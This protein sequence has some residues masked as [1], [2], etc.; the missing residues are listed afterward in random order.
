[1]QE[2]FFPGRPRASCAC[3]GKKPSGPSEAKFAERI[4]DTLESSVGFFLLQ[5]LSVD[6]SSL[7]LPPPPPRL[8][9]L[10]AV[11]ARR[12]VPLSCS[13]LIGGKRLSQLPPSRKLPSQNFFFETIPSNYSESIWRLRKRKMSSFLR[14]AMT[15]TNPAHF[16][17]KVKISSSDET[18]GRG[19]QL[20]S[21]IALANK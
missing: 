8:I 7:L 14:R 5:T 1:M 4:L 19:N 13:R 2:A 17:P 21:I 20:I 10:L 15:T 12:S 18:V 6:P 11:V 9:C 16:L 3:A